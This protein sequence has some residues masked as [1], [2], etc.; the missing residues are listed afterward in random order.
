MGVGDIAGEAMGLYAQVSSHTLTCRA[1]NKA[2]EFF[3][4]RNADEPVCL[5]LVLPSCV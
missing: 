3:N 1:D 2:F 4:V 5:P